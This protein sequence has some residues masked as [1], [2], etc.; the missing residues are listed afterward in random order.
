VAGLVVAAPSGMVAVL[1]DVL[2]VI[3]A[4]N[5]TLACLSLVPALP[6]DGGRV[7]RALA[8]AGTGDRDRA[9]LIT[10][11]A[12]RLVGWVIVAAGVALALANLVLEGLVAVALG[13]LLTTSGRSV[14][15]RVA[16]E[17]LLR[18]VHVE[19]AMDREVGSIAPQLTIDTFADRLQGPDG[20]AALP[21]VDGDTVVGIV[22]RR[23]LM[24]LGRRR[25][26][27]TRVSEVMASPP[28]TPLL[29]PDDSLWDALELLSTG[30]L[31]ALAVADQGRL[32]GMLTRD[33]V[34]T[35]VRSLAAR[36]ATGS[37]GEAVR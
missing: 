32:A 20:I 34:A 15:R 28:Q 37:T 10:A 7:V 33:G 17:R 26:G 9:S 13:W 31:D 21:V 30:S 3:G 25:F 36:Q 24:G 8:W 4:L 27:G 5:L 22:G 18:G 16:M 14:E 19:D 29:A 23:R 11:R 12:G 6:I 35:L 1:A 2:V